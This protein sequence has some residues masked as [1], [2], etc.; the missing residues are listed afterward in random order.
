MRLIQRGQCSSRNKDFISTIAGPRA[1]HWINT[2]LSPLPIGCDGTDRQSV[3]ICNAFLFFFVYVGRHWPDF[4]AFAVHILTYLCWRGHPYSIFSL[5]SSRLCQ[6]YHRLT[7]HFIWPLI[8]QTIG[9]QWRQKSTHKHTKLEEATWPWTQRAPADLDANNF[10]WIH[11]GARLEAM[12]TLLLYAV[13]VDLTI[14]S[15]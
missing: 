14:T 15:V 10:F 11:D 12:Q 2:V 1:R 13:H 4:A 3:S 9:A 7:S 8:T 5:E 6:F